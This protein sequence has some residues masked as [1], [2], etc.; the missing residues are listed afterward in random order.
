[1]ALVFILSLLW[2]CHDFSNVVSLFLTAPLPVHTSPHLTPISIFCLTDVKMNHVRG[3]G[4]GAQIRASHSQSDPVSLG[5]TTPLHVG[6]NWV[7][8]VFFFL[9]STYSKSFLQNNPF[10]L[11]CVVIIR[12][13]RNGHFEPFYSVN[14]HF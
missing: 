3:S 14:W 13:T 7:Y 6:P 1:M 11:M 4:A 12:V 10:G 8:K 5:K 2:K 9:K